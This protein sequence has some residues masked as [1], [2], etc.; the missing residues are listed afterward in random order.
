MILAHKGIISIES[1]DLF[2][3]QIVKYYGVLCEIIADHDPRFMSLFWKQPFA[4]LGT[5]VLHSSSHHP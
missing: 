1:V 3:Q 5:S 4:Q 2:L